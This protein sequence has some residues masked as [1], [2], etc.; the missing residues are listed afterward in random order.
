MMI[1]QYTASILDDFQMANHLSS[2]DFPDLEIDERTTRTHQETRMQRGVVPDL[3]RRR[4]KSEFYQ[5]NNLVFKCSL[6]KSLRS[7]I[8]VQNK[9]S[10]ANKSLPRARWNH[11]MKAY[12][13]ELLKDYNV[14]GYR[15][16]NAWSNEAWNSITNRI[17]Q[18]FGLSLAVAQVK[19]KEQ[20]L[21][22]DFRSV[23]DLA[24]ESGFGWDP[25]RMMVVAP[26]EVWETFG[27]RINKDSL[28]WR[29]K[30]FPYF[31]DLFVLYEGK[32]L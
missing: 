10:G 13:I 7:V 2:L 20:D 25:N 27:E 17:N 16:Q 11:Q 32:F 23:K 31:D 26:D 15:T 4:S 14:P 22:K 5:L 19:Q 29:D 24:G 21:K 8:Y 18:K 3:G 30:S 28:R 9:I 12:L 6:T 1:P